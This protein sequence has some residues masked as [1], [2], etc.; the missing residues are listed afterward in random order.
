MNAIENLAEA[1]QEVKETTMS[2][3]WHEIY[4]DLI[5][6]ISG[7]GQP[8]QNV[9]EEIIMLAHEAGF[10]EIN[11]QDVVE[12]LESYGE[13]LSNE[14]LMEMEQQRAEEEEK[15]ELH[16]AEPPRVLTTKDL[17]EAFQLLDRA[18]AI[19]TEKDPDRER[20]AEANRIITSGY[21]CYRELYEKKKEQARQQTL[22]RFLEIPA[23]EE[24]GS[25]S[26]D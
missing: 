6:D 12:L 25:K 21:K 22:D 8:L 1:W 2:L 23:N 15:D 3:A 13:E 5:A 10:N 26:L 17:S 14:D 24:I 19:F 16:D 7:F 9:H 4:P 11:E 20:S 18:M